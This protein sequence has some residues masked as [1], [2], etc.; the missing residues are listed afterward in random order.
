MGRDGKV[1][2]SV[3][4]ED[5]ED[6]D[7]EFKRKIEETGDMPKADLNKTVSVHSSP[8]VEVMADVETTS[9]EEEEE[10]NGVAEQH[11]DN[12]ATNETRESV[13]E[14]SKEV[15]KLRAANFVKIDRLERS[16]KA[17]KG[18]AMQAGEELKSLELKEQKLLV[19]KTDLN[20][21]NRLLQMGLRR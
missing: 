15:A 18:E 19:R 10:V 6:T 7:L 11:V 13:E 4:K 12:E 2:G 8:E 17:L 1:P 3:V 9:E 16:L 14:K 20:K 21:K 5:C